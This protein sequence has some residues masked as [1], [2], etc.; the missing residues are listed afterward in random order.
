MSGPTMTPAQKAQ[1]I[2]TLRNAIEI[3][4]ATQPQTPCSTCDGFK[5]KHCV[6]WGAVVP[7]DAQAAGC[8]RWF[9]IPF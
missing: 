6:E 7:P 5:D 8:D 4:E 9:A 3:I 2:K 1:A